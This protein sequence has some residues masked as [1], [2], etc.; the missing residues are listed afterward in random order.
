MRYL[1]LV[2]PLRHESPW[3]NW[4][5][6]PGE[7]VCSGEVSLSRLG[8]MIGAVN[9]DEHLVV[10]FGGGA[11]GELAGAYGLRGFERI[12]PALGDASRGGAAL[13]GMMRR[14]GPCDV[15]MAWGSC[16]R[17]LRRK[18]HRRGAAWIEVDPRT[19]AMTDRTR[20]GSPGDAGSLDLWPS[21]DDAPLRAERS[22]ARSALG[23]TED[24]I[25]LA[26]VSDDACP[27][28]GPDALLLAASI[29]VLSN[30][31]VVL[32]PRRSDRVAWARRTALLGGYAR[33][34]VMMD[35]A[36]RRWLAAADAAVMIPAAPSACPFGWATQISWCQDSGVA[37]VVPRRVAEAVS[38]GSAFAEEIGV[39]DRQRPT[40]L[41]SKVA[42]LLTNP[43]ARRRNVAAW[44]GLRARHGG[45]GAASMLVMLESRALVTS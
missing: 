32:L 21:I 8:G 44:R 17:G 38:G 28:D 29:Q 35:A 26:L 1:H 45:D 27:A 3:W 18:S 6:L 7:D 2:Q 34:V 12:A 14:A 25:A 22:R 37:V 36:P 16:F 23:L 13:R 30:A 20:A 4:G 31:A 5:E 40:A 11:A 19:G 43:E 15:I 42:S 41:A 9:G 10:I 24:D 39:A 33:R